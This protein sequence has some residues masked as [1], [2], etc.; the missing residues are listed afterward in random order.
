MSIITM[1]GVENKCISI[2]NVK[3]YQMINDLIQ[4]GYN[5]V[6]LY[7]MSI[8]ELRLELYNPLTN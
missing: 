8:N 4:Q 6:E 2:K 7:E 3:R 1:D 5:E